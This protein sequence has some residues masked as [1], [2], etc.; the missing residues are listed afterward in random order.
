MATFS[1]YKQFVIKSALFFG[2]AKSSQIQ[3]QFQIKPNAQIACSV[4]YR[5]FF[6]FFPL[7]FV[8][9]GTPSPGAICVIT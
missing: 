1:R 9:S 8:I 6:Y 3:N 7:L 4:C 5:P 2:F